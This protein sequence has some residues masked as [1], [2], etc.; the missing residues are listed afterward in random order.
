MKNA[1]IAPPNLDLPELQS[2]S[3]GNGES[4]S[5]TN[6]FDQGSWRVLLINPQH[7]TKLSSRAAIQL[8]DFSHSAN[9]ETSQVEPLKHQVE[10]F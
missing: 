10:Q 9:P 6:Q 4:E 5:P 7:Q 3:Q 1:A 2:E 8:P